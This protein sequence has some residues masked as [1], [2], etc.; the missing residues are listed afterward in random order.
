MKLIREATSADYPVLVEIW[1]RAVHSSHDFLSEADIAEIREALIQLYFPNVNIY[2]I[3]IDRPIHAHGNGQDTT[4]QTGGH[5]IAGFIGLLDS[6]IEML[7]IDSQYQGKGYGSVLIDFAIR[8]SAVAVDVNEQNSS[9][10]A[11][12]LSKG[13]RIVSRDPT[14]ESNRPFPILHLSRQQIS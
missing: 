3:E 13:F 9:A 5:T 2:A 1:E 12:Y 7:F 4:P 14:D 6:K 11:F 8:E 10:L